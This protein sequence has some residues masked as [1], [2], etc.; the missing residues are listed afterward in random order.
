M[1][2]DAARTRARRV[3]W[4]VHGYTALGLVLAAGMGVLIVQGTDQ[5]LRGAL[6]LMAAAFAV[7][8]TDG[9]L[10]RR[11]RIAEVL[12]EVDGRRLDDLIDF[13]TFAT[14]PLL[15]I[16]RMDLLPG[17]LGGVLVAA[18]LASAFGF[19]RR[20]AKTEDGFFLGFPSYWN[21]VAFYFFFL[22]P[23]PAVAATLVLVLAVLTVLPWKY[24][25]PGQ[26]G[27]PLNRVT[28][29]LGAAWGLLVV[30]IL[31]GWAEGV[32]WVTASLTFPGYY[33]V[34]SWYVTHRARV[35]RLWKR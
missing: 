19:S 8:A 23:R 34:L 14:L 16:W 7:D 20:D 27:Q 25:N 32:G 17:A 11:Y 1:T 22:E 12:P 10:A 24:L 35:G 18:L 33:L 9:T 5:A 4:A 13:H 2:S 6:L 29:P 26:R 3:A 21:V 31:V 28:V 30:A 15:L